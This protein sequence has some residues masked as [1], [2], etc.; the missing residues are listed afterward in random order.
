M[1][2]IHHPRRYLLDIFV[3]ILLASLLVFG[4]LY[5]Y[6][7]NNDARDQQLDSAL[8]MQGQQYSNDLGCVACHTVDGSPGIGP[9]WVN[10]W[11][12][13]ET[14]LAQRE[15]L[16]VVV[17]EAYIRESIQAPAAKV[18]KDYPNVMT[19]YFLEE[20]QTTALIAYIKALGKPQN[21][22]SP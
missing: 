7:L 13:T 12:R 16:S 2:L 5:I 1:N 15:Q 6:Q 9:S 18:V 8:A 21:P 20:P 19:P 17:N 4:S 10:M 22:A 11:G 3:G 14:V